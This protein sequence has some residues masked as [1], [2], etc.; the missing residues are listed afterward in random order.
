[1]W[2]TGSF[3]LVTSHFSSILEVKEAVTEWVC[4]IP[5]IFWSLL[6]WSKIS[7]KDIFPV[8]DTDLSLK[9]KKPLQG[10][11]ES[12]GDAVQVTL[13]YEGHMTVWDLSVNTSTRL[14]Y[15]LVHR[16]TKARYSRFTIRLTDSKA[17]ISDS[18]NLTLGL[19][20][21]SHGGIIEISFAF[22]HRRRLS[23]VTVRQGE[24]GEQ[25]VFLPQDAPILA[26]L[27]YLDPGE[28]GNMSDMQLW[29]I[30]PNASFFS[31]LN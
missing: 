8:R 22:P 31:C 24:G 26:I 17:T 3:G 9:G 1:M 12:S 27:G 18:A 29:Y 28:F 16:A 2:P 15:C 10:T 6:T 25:V 13:I 4:A 11:S 21:L 30:L 7:G 20:D 14:L 23:E 19:T 5:F